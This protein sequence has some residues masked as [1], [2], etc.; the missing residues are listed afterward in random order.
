MLE[1]RAQFG[2][3][4][5]MRRNAGR[6]A[7]AG[8]GTVIVTLTAWEAQGQPYP[9]RPGQ[10][11]P[12]QPLPSRPARLDEVRGTKAR[13]WVGLAQQALTQGRGRIESYAWEDIAT[14]QATFGDVQG[15][16]KS[17]TMPENASDRIRALVSVA[18]VLRDRG[19]IPG[20]KNT[21]AAASRELANVPART[22]YTPWGTPMQDPRDL[23]EIGV[24]YARL[25]DVNE[26]IR[27]AR[28]MSPCWEKAEVLARM[29]EF[30]A[31]HGNPRAARQMFTEAKADMR[32][33][34]NPLPPFGYAD[35]AYLELAAG[36]V[37][38]ARATAQSQVNKLSAA[39]TLAT[40]S[41]R[42][43]Q[44]HGPNAQAFLKDAR[45]AYADSP[46]REDTNAQR[47]RVAAE[48]AKAHAAIGEG[49]EAQRTIGEAMRAAQS[50][51]ATQDYHPQVLADVSIAAH[52]LGDEQIAKAAWDRAMNDMAYLPAADRVRS[53]WAIAV[54]KAWT[55]DVATA[56]TMALD[57]ARAGT[58]ELNVM[59]MQAR[60]IAAGM[61]RSSDV[62][63]DLSWVPALIDRRQQ[64]VAYAAAAAELATHRAP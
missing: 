33:V 35:I 50:T 54:K 59:C 26:V 18:D 20:A 45:Q 8:I 11:L 19:E 32:Y 12:M 40:L 2:Q 16:L 49:R 39:G 47:A 36:W 23:H 51:P 64:A 60:G 61:V 29:G 15:A 57:A 27:I 30:H 5:C 53:L 44:T 22:V 34:S 3:E 17:A 58:I 52:I 56:R 14:T 21:L 63:A 37:D 42:E 41:L 62:N 28:A 10:P 9:L 48:I 6:W 7:A 4:V 43:V 25:G 55:G 13:E 31:A 1:M 46:Q 38:D 24:G